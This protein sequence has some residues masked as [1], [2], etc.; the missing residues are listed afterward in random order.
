MYKALITKLNDPDLSLH[1]TIM[2]GGFNYLVVDKDNK[3]SKYSLKDSDS[4]FL[5]QRKNSLSSSVTGNNIAKYC[6]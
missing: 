3:L 1:N 6:T 2:L 4:M 5:R